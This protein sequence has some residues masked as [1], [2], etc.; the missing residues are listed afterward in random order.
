MKKKIMENHQVGQITCHLAFEFRTKISHH[1]GQFTILSGI[2]LNK[3]RNL[4]ANDNLHSSL[5]SMKYWIKNWI[6]RI[7]IYA[8]HVVK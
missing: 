2:E 6:E 3:S 7:L 4:Y 5:I 8:M 1:R